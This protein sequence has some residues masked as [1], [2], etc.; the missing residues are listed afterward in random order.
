M[1]NI[2]WQI[3]Y[4]LSIPYIILMTCQ[5]LIVPGFTEFILT[6][7]LDIHNVSQNITS[8]TFKSCN[9]ASS[10]AMGQ[11]SYQ[12]LHERNCT[13]TAPEGKDLRVFQAEAYLDFISMCL[14]HISCN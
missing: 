4:L 13:K 7:P 2:H 3:G 5:P 1:N 10:A 14:L 6:A 8:S 9:P 11:E 12:I